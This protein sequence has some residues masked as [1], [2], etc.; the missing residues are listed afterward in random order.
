MVFGLSTAQVTRPGQH[1]AWF[2]PPANNTRH[3]SSPTGSVDGRIIVEEDGGEVADLTTITWQIGLG[4]TLCYRFKSETSNLAGTVE[5]TYVSLKSI[6]SIMDSY[7]FPLV[8]SSV[9]CLCDCPGG[10]SQCDSQ[11]NMCGNSTNCANYYNPSVKSQGCFFKFLQL[12]AAMCCS[13]Q[14]QPA[15]RER[16]RAVHL[17]VPNIMAQF[18]TVYKNEKG[19]IVDTRSYNIDLNSGSTI[20]WDV[21]LQVSSPGPTTLVPSGWY[22]VPDHP[23]HKHT[24]LPGLDVNGLDGWDIHKLGWLKA[25]KLGAVVTSSLEQLVQSYIPV[26]K[27]CAAGK[28]EG[29]FTSGIEIN[30]NEVGGQGRSLTEVYPFI[31]GVR[32]WRRHVEMK[33][34]ES[35]LLALTLQHRSK[36]G[37][38]VQSSSS[39]LSDFT[40]VLYQDSFSHL[41]LNL[42]LFQASG[43][44]TGLITGS[45]SSQS[46][47]L[48][49]P[50]RPSN[51]THQVKL[52][53]T[54][55]R[56]GQVKVS[57]RPLSLQ[58]LSVTKHLPCVAESMRTFR[59]TPDLTLPVEASSVVDCL[60]CGSAWLHW[61]DPGHWLE[62]GWPQTRVVIVVTMAVITFI[63]LLLVCKLLRWTC[64]C[65]GCS[66]SKKP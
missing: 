57:L 15:S 46:I 4:E 25:G 26:V 61:L 16:Y 41:H 52:T 10:S 9:Q 58:K 49:L 65:F 22:V 29:S 31:S 62:T 43:T 1:H 35:P 14:V 21:T 36:V 3:C 12:S 54:E 45:H 5:V 19:D 48:R 56:A 23:S 38:V 44:I 30:K 63:I 33:H 34:G 47:L 42:S 39:R 37:V 60:S 40:G 32:I 53:A 51:S 17:A 8:K 13:I 24:L 27:N 59:S 55:C 20:D 50:L 18:K 64:K 66:S 11:S 2:T 7:Q 6:Y 28:Y